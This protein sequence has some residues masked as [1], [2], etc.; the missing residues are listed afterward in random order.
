[1]MK[2]LSMASCALLLVGCGKSPSPATAPAPA[3]PSAP[4]PAAEAPAAAAPAAATQA[5]A[6][7]SPTPSKS[8]SGAKK[9]SHSGAGTIDT[10]SGRLRLQPRKK[11]PHLEL[12]LDGDGKA[13]SMRAGQDG[14]RFHAEIR[15]GDT[16]LARREAEGSLTGWMRLPVRRGRGRH[17]LFL[18][19]TGPDDSAP[20]T[21]LAQGDGGRFRIEPFD[22]LPVAHW[23]LRGDGVE[24]V[25]GI[26]TELYQ[27]FLARGRSE[28]LD[29]SGAQPVSV[30]P[31]P[32]FEVCVV[33]PDD[34]S[35]DAPLRLVVARR[36]VAEIALMATDEAGKMAVVA[37]RNVDRPDDGSRWSIPAGFALAC[38]GEGKVQFKARHYRID[39]DALLPV[40]DP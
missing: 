35:G 20:R 17:A 34:A 23:D 38:L 4:A 3:A 40:P 13:E 14:A 25:H 5:A 36:D 33:D 7:A 12:D 10:S 24:V 39:G 28:L 8:G 1:M 18:Q 16:V 29:L 21:W 2:R 30:L 31:G 27:D 37:K 19:F 6:P 9:A 26:T 11:A 32:T 15:H 22:W